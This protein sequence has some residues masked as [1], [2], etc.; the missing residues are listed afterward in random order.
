M[1]EGRTQRLA[2][3][4]L[5]DGVQ[6]APFVAEVVDRQDIRMRERGDRPS[7]TLEPGECLVVLFEIQ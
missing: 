5:R 4:K 7:L 1:S 6:D 3:E 2:F